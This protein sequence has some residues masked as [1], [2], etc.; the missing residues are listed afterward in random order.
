MRLAI[1]RKAGKERLGAQRC[2]WA[3]RECRHPCARG[4]AGQLVGTLS[5]GEDRQQQ[6]TP[7]GFAT[8]RSH[9]ARKQP[10]PTLTVRFRGYVNSWKSEKTH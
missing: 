7:V 6:M 1:S 8:G 4:G 3:L 5:A 2:C 9:L 10:L